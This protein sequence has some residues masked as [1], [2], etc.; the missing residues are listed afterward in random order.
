AYVK[1]S[2]GNPVEILLE[3][4]DESGVWYG[5]SET[6]IRFAVKK[7]GIEVQAGE[8]VSCKIESLSQGSGCA[9]FVGK[10]VDLY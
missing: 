5:F 1:R 9:V 2:V 3:H 4:R 10:T 8:I 6:Y 7:I